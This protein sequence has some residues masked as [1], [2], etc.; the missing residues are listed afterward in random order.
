MQILAIVL[1]SKTGKRRILNLEPG[2]VNVITGKSRTGK[3]ALISIVDYCLG[4]GSCKVARGPIRNTVSWYGLLLQFQKNQLFIARQNPEGKAKSTNVSYILEGKRLDIP[5]DPPTQN[6]TIDDVVKAIGAKLGISPNLH[7]PPEGQTRPPL[8]ANFR[9]AL[10]YSFQAQN[11]ITNQKI[12]FHRQDEPEFTNII[13]DTLPYFLGVIREDALALQQELRK[14]QRDLKIAR[15][16]LREAED[17][18]GEGISK[19]LRLLGEARQLGLIPETFNASLNDLESIITVLQQVLEWTPNQMEYSVANQLP[20]L[21]EERGELQDSWQR[22][23]ESL[24]AVKTYAQEVEGYASAAD[25]QV[26][27]LGSIGFYEEHEHNSVACPVCQQP[28]GQLIP[29]IEAIKAHL[30]ELNEQLGTIE[31]DRPQLRQTIEA[32]EKTKEE[33]EAKI[34]AKYEEIQALYEQESALAR[35]RD[36]DIAR[37]RV[38][39]RISLWLESVNQDNDLAELQGKVTAAEYKVADLDG[40]LSVALRRNRLETVLINLGTQMTQWSNQLNLE[41]SGD[42]TFVQLDWA[43]AGLLV[44]TLTEE[45]P[46]SEIGSGE[47]WLA[48]HLIV[49]F[50]LHS[51]FVKQKRPTPRFLFLDQPTQVYFPEDQ[52]RSRRIKDSGQL[53]EGD[54]TSV[55]KIFNFI[56]DFAEALSP[57]FQIIISDHANLLKNKRFQ[58]SIR[59]VWRDGAALIPQEW[60]DEMKILDENAAEGDVETESD[61]D[62]E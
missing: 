28:M 20:R 58:S 12:L 54:R 49:H 41:H 30:D 29:T 56:L 53:E 59:E 34:R 32:L 14:A 52:G 57:N 1:Y 2:K 9:H 43:R 36:A 61:V 15:R 62:T 46:L 4:R 37:G 21:I 38:V 10:L 19:A 5:V 44:N 40:K 23:E 7:I 48:Y 8:S 33:L 47:N 18:R 22:N 51:H 16:E 24:E 31:R 11:E 50:A 17:I 6:T 27:R 26:L 25:E 35:L 55:E 39:G 45:I 13:K 42:G 60:L 3:S